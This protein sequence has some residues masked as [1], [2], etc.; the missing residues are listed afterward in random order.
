ML[1]PLFKGCQSLGLLSVILGSAGFVLE[2]RPFTGITG[3]CAVMSLVG[4]LCLFSFLCIPGEELA[5]L[6][7]VSPELQK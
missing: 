6:V 7:T 4:A 2:V 5:T 1:K 3:G